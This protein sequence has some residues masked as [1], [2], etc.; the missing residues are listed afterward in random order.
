MLNESQQ[1]PK[2]R[3]Q[4]STHKKKK[5]RMKQTISKS[6]SKKEGKRRKNNKSTSR[7]QET[8]QQHARGIR[9]LQARKERGGSVAPRRNN[10]ITEPATKESREAKVKA[11]KPIQESNGKRQDETTKANEKGTRNGTRRT[12]K[13]ERKNEEIKKKEKKKKEKGKGKRQGCPGGTMLITWV[14]TGGTHHDD[15]GHTQASVCR[16][17]RLLPPASVPCLLYT[18]PSP[19]D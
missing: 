7:T 12:T 2:P 19:R 18:S 6:E 4:H 9:I 1:K 10:G 5:D 3:R 13:K 11:K 14:S 15:D 17:D 16:A 8:R